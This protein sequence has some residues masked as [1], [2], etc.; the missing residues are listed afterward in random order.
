MKILLLSVL[1]AFAKLTELLHIYQ[2]KTGF[3]G[4]TDSL[5]HVHY[6]GVSYSHKH[7]QAALKAHR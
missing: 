1:K 5:T 7:A 4:T 2:Y 6:M 3:R